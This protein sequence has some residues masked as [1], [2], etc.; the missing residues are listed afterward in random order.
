MGQPPCF[1]CLTSTKGIRGQ[2]RVQEAA[3][4]STEGKNNPVIMGSIVLKGE[5]RI[6]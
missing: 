3:M 1:G 4:T 5:G 2:V 6:K